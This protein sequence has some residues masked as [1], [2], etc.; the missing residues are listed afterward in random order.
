MTNISSKPPARSSEWAWKQTHF[1]Q[2]K[3]GDKVAYIHATNR[4]KRDASYQFREIE[5]LKT[6]YDDRRI[7]RYQVNVLRQV[8]VKKGLAKPSQ[9]SKNR[10]TPDALTVDRNCFPVED[11]DKEIQKKVNLT[12]ATK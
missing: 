1:H 12:N 8:S 11:W 5:I 10:V 2:F 6:G 3:Q 7:P 9:I 4:G